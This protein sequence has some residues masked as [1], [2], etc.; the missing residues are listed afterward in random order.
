MSSNG[1]ALTLDIRPRRSP[2]LAWCLVA[3]HAATLGVLLGV[4]PPGLPLFCLLVALGGSLGWSL[5]RQVF[6]VGTVTARLAANDSWQVD[7]GDGQWQR[8]TL[9]GSF[10]HSWLVIL[11]LKP[12]GSS[13][14]FTILVPRGSIPTDTFRRLRARLR[15]ASAQA[16]EGVRV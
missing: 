4:I 7:R 9:V 14:A 13:A 5:W 15:L 12:I 6:N 11:N 10:V 8:A 16:G 2:A 1:F 3:V